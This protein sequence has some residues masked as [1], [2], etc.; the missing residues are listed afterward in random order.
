MLNPSDILCV[1]TAATTA[2]T[3]DRHKEIINGPIK[4]AFFTS[5]PTQRTFRTFKPVN[6][7]TLKQ[8]R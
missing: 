4:Y 3:K 8:L 7:Q 5:Y 2:V 1:A 6:E